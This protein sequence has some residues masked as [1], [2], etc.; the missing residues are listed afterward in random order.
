MPKVS[1]I[2]VNYR[3][4]DVTLELLES[5]QRQ[6]FQDIEVIV[7]DNA[8]LKPMEDHFS[9]QYQWVNF[10]T[11]TANLGFAG[12]NNVGIEAAQG[13]YFFFI[14]N[15]TE[16]VGGCIAMLVD[17]L[18]KT[19]KAGMVSP[20]IVY[21]TR[22]ENGD[23]LMQYAGMT[24]L[25]PITGRNVKIGQ[26]QP[27]GKFEHKGQIIGKADSQPYQTAYAHGAGM[28]IRRSV[29]EK[30]GRMPEDFFLYYEEMD[31]SQQ[32][33][34]ADYE[35]WVEPRTKVYHKESMTTGKMGALKSYFTNRNR[36]LFMRR[37][38]S[39]LGFLSFCFFLVFITM[40]K[41]SI[42]FLL[43]GDF[44]N[45]KAFWEG[46][47]WNVRPNKQHRFEQLAKSNTKQSRSGR[48]IVAE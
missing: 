23:E 14:N 27:L 17:F 48:L 22:G 24:K 33:W 2:T 46:V 10:I 20:L 42:Q 41:N 5:I 37:N 1:I 26:Y 47:W 36:V 35:V 40:P 18:E 16:L 25:H 44:E 19:P 6:D 12:G 28:M 13:E 15:D 3:Q 29:V 4:A 11:C 43:Q 38:A 45:L 32:V 7:V 9:A 30:V 31:W 34:N 8:P 39:S 21:H